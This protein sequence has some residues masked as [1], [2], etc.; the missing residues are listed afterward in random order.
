MFDSLQDRCLFRCTENNIELTRQDY[1]KLG[2]D[3]P[4]LRREPK[5]FD[6]RVTML[7]EITVDILFSTK[8]GK[9]LRIIHV[10]YILEHAYSV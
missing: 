8:V 2:V 1:Q 3:E 5:Q 6:L 4:G 7:A 9:L 10:E